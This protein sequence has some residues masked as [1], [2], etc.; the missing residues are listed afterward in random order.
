MGYHNIE[1]YKVDYS[2]FKKVS[3]E[4]V[5]IV[6]GQINPTVKRAELSDRYLVFSE[7]GKPHGVIGRVTSIDFK[8]GEIKHHKTDGFYL[9]RLKR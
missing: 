2:T 4:K 8:E 6:K 3:N 5:E 1:G 9:F 7:E